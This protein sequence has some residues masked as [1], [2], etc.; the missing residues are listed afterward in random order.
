MHVQFRLGQ[1]VDQLLQ[2]SSFREQDR[3]GRYGI[4]A[5]NRFTT[6]AAKVLT[7]L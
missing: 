7:H 3:D 5:F 4:S 2:H 6:L 1:R